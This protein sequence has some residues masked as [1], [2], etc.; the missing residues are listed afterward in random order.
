[1]PTR[2]QTYLKTARA[3]DRRERARRDNMLSRLP[4][5]II[6]AH[7]HI[8]REQ[9]VLPL[10]EAVERHP[11][12]TYAAYDLGEAQVSKATLW[13]GKR[14][15]SLRMAHATAG[16][17]HRAIN[18]YLLEATAGTDDL[19]IAYGLPDDIE[20]TRRLVRHPDVRALKMYYRYREPSA[21]TITAVFPEA[22]LD[23]CS[24]VG[25]PILLHLPRLLPDGLEDL[26]GVL[27]RWPDL[28][29]VVAHLGGG[30]MQ[31]LGPWHREAFSRLSRYENLAMDTAWIADGPVIREAVSTLGSERVVFGTDEP[32]SLIRAG[33]FQHPVHGPWLFGPRYHWHTADPAMQPPRPVVPSLLHLEQVA[34][35]LEATVGDAAT[36]DKVMFQNAARLY[37]VGREETGGREDG[38]ANPR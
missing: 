4:D 17:D 30:G 10:P 36:L 29:M 38:H 23:E 11:I 22:V 15:T 27:T 28:M 1:M 18:R 2:S 25:K 13:P 32:L 21:S 9:D 33:V 24:R 16:F 35:V 3:L 7:A 19:V 31:T 5:R 37:G 8:A 6:D 26:V 34:A 12:S 20:Y 14:V